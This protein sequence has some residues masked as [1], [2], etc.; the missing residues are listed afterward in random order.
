[1]LALDASSTGHELA[2][3]LPDVPLTVLTNS[4]PAA[5]MLLGRQQTRVICT[6]GILEPR[7]RSLLGSLAEEALRRF[8][9]TKFFLSAK[10]VCPRRGL[11]EASDDQARFKQAL[12]DLADQSY[13]LVDSSKLGVRS[14]V[15]Y[16]GVADV[17]LLIT[18]AAANAAILRE[19]EQLGLRTQLAPDAK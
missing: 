17:D 9:V 7:S 6:G 3:R 10:G 1:M 8:H 4:L 13:L 19:L 15:F 16:A 18:D 5:V 2:R 11:S 14:V 12:L